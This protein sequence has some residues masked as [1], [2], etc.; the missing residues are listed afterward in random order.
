ASTESHTADHL[1][2]VLNSVIVQVG[3]TLFSGICSDDTGNTR[4]ARQKVQKKHPWIINMPDPC[5]RLNLLV[6][7]I[8]GLKEFQ[9]V[10]KII[11]RSL[12]FF[13]KL[14]H[15]NSH[16]KE[17]QKKHN[18]NHGLVS[19]GKT[20]FG[21]IYFSG[22]SVQQCLPAI[23][24]LCGNEIVIIPVMKLNWPLQDVQDSFMPD[25]AATLQFQSA[26]LQLLAVIGPPAKATKCLESAFSNIADVFVFWL[27]VQASFEE[28]LKKNTSSL[29]VA[30]LEKIRCLFNYRFNQSINDVPTDVF[31]TAFFLDP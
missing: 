8:C 27:A 21:T 1:F 4:V 26:L 14:T 15:A 16:L 12:K 17:R 24:E 29:S 10:I 13:K 19:I 28:I 25:T 9:P 30:V 11:C 23:R 2:R 5:H 3:P 18:I 31:V 20:H 6:K 22:V 7:N